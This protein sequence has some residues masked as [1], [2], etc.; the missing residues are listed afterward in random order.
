VVI[1]LL[2]VVV[3]VVVALWLR[4]SFQRFNEAFAD[5]IQR[6]GLELF[7]RRLREDVLTKRRPMDHLTVTRMMI[8]VLDQLDQAAPQSGQAAVVTPPDA[9]YRLACEE[10]VALQK[11]VRTPNGDY[12][13]PG[14]VRHARG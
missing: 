4:R 6:H 3:A 5:R 8:E 11:L 2:V 10:L 14:A 12:V 7:D 9:G 13:R 1:L